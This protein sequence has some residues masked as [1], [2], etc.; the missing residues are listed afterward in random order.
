[1]P[2]QRKDSIEDKLKTIMDGD[3]KERE[4]MISD[5]LPFI[6]KTVSNKTNR[7]IEMENSPEY[8]I[9][10]EAFNEAIDKYDSAKGKFI[11]FATLVIKSRTTDFMRKEKKRG[12]VITFTE[13]GESQCNELAGESN[14]DP[15]IE[16]ISLKSEIE[17]FKNTLQEFNISLSELVEKSPKHTKVKVRTLDIATYIFENIVLNNELMNKK[18][19]PISYITKKLK[20]SSKELS[21][22]RK[23][24]IATVIILNSDLELIKQYILEVKGG[25]LDD[26]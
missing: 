8:M 14:I 15:L 2:E 6:I 17:K 1:M 5:Y 22:Y 21:R 3:E 20:V 13:L 16:S 25:G 9:G 18:R 26:I 4:K 23:Y 11:D 10:I 7:Y 24:I 19:L 12:N